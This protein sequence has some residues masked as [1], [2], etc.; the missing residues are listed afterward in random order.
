MEGGATQALAQHYVAKR[1]IRNPDNLC[2]SRSVAIFNTETSL[3]SQQIIQSLTTGVSFTNDEN[4]A[5]IKH[6]R[7]WAS[8]M[9]LG[10]PSSLVMM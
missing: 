1:K 8:M 6:M 5:V 10:V 7:T 9:S 3:P 4:K 2:Q